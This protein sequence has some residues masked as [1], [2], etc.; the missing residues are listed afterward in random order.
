MLPIL[1]EILDDPSWGHVL[2]Y[3]PVDLRPLFRLDHDNIH[4]KPSRK[5]IKVEDKD[6]ETEEG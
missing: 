6:G 4:Y 3:V 2:A 5:L 1:A